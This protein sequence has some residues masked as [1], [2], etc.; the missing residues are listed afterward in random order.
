M[1]RREFIGLVGGA[2]AAWPLA[3]AAQQPAKPVVGF[4]NSASADG[5]EA[6]VAAFKKGLQENGYVADQNVAIEY[7]WADSQ[8]DRLPAL[9]A[10]LVR[11][12]VAVIAASGSPNPAQAAKAATAT[13]PIVF[14]YGGDPIA[15]GLVA[16]LA[17]PGANITGVTFYSNV[18]MAKRLGLVRELLPNADVIAVLINPDNASTENDTR[19]AREFARDSGKKIVIVTASSEGEIDTA[20]A[21]AVQHKARALLID[22]DGLFRTRSNQLIALAARYSLPA[23]YADREYAIEGGLMS[24][25]PVIADGY[26]QCGNYVGQVL[27][28]AKP[29]D[30]PVLQPTK[31]NF[32]LNLKT[33]KTLGLTIPPGVLAI[34]DEVIE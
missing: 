29:G 16:N 7:R 1:R 33:A 18:V 30:L 26:R 19:H 32:V 5:Y 27:K 13:I 20:V 34:A 24:Y 2:A 4:L 10:D 12:Q 6:R 17:R 14:A 25:G 31:F 15:N 8:F 3:A 28:G 23:S 11:R 22:A 9:A 21:D